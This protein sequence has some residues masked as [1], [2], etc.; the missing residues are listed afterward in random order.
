MRCASIH[1][2]LSCIGPGPDFKKL[3]QLS[4][5][6]QAGPVCMSSRLLQP[7]SQQELQTEYQGLVDDLQAAGLFPQAR[8]VAELADLPVD[9]LLINQVRPQHKTPNLSDANIPGDFE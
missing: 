7:C 1:L 8:Q 4:E 5:I 3:S 6:L 2:T 9:S